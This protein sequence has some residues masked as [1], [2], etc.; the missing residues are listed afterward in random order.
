MVI[1]LVFGL[2]VGWFI[3]LFGAN[4]LIIQG[5]FELTGKEISIAGYYTIFAF[6]GLVSGLLNKRH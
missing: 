6:L 5:I 4:T 1:G 3:S 2:I